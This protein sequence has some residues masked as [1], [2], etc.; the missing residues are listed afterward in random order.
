MRR[1]WTAW[2]AWG[3]WVAAVASV[4]GE[5]VLA[6]SNHVPWHT[7]LT[8]DGFA[9]EFGLFFPAA[10]ALIASRRPENPIGWILSVAGLSQALEGLSHRW[11]QH[12]LV[13]APRSLPLGHLAAWLQAG[14]W[15]PG[16][17]ALP[18]VEAV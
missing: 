10:G 11:A 2:L 12:T 17:L 7:V 4:A 8:A 18:L 3:V 14:I 16:L 1:G 13:A 6:T 9:V 15:L 5:V